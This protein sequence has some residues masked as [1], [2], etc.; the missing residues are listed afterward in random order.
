VSIL[1]DNQTKVIVQGVTGRDGSFHTQLMLDYGTQVVAGVTP[2]KEGQR[3]ADVPVF[4]TV[5]RAVAASGAT[6]SIIF[7]PAKFAADAIR[8]AADGGI[9]LVI[10]ITEGV[11]VLEMVKLYHELKQKHVRLIGPNCP[12]I[13]SPGKSKMGIMPAHIHKPGRVGVISRSGTLTYEIVYNLTQSGLGQS[14][15]LGIG[16]D[17]IVGTGYIE[18]LEMFEQD[19]DTDVVVIIGEIGGQEEEKA[20]A[21][22]QA[23]MRKKIVAF[24]SGRFA[25]PGKRMG[26]AGAI[27]SGGKG[28]A[29]AKVEAFHRAGVTVVDRPDQ[30]PKA[31]LRD[32]G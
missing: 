14:T 28:G 7:V 26:H 24:I 5:A 18:L 32:K 30:I 31:I 10:C 6:A 8:E 20:A 9:S 27:I 11:P 3:V 21:F 16:G 13:I 25:P 15:C 2:G 23:S 29:E 12:G 4:D 22:I 19:D 17:P 1:I